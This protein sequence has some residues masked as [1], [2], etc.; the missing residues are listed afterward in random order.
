MERATTG[1]AAALAA[2]T[3]GSRLASCREGLRSPR[4]LPAARPSRLSRNLRFR[5]PPWRRVCTRLRRAIQPIAI[6][7]CPFFVRG[8]ETR[9]GGGP[10][11]RLATTAVPVGAEVI[12]TCGSSHRPDGPARPGP[13]TRPSPGLPS[14]CSQ[15]GLKPGPR[16]GG[17]L[18]APS[19][20]RG[21]E[22]P[23]LV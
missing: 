14:K 12:R 23:L 6:A 1:S 10:S 13:E 16:T 8:A 5:A 2:E 21:A 9:C 22:T 20:L 11:P 17:V 4:L 18:H 19:R 7:H 15:V 3:L